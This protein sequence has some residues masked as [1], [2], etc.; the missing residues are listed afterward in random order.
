LIISKISL[1]FLVTLEFNQDMRFPVNLLKD[2]N[3]IFEIT[4]F[5]PSNQLIS[6]D[7]TRGQYDYEPNLDF[8]ATLDSTTNT[9]ININMNF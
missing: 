1:Q 7:Q 4:V 9:K 8:K 6:P 5:N 3:S 2:L